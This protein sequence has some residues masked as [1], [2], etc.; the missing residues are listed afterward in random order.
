MSWSYSSLGWSYGV[1]DYQAISVG[2]THGFLET[3]SPETVNVVDFVARVVEP[4][5]ATARPR[6]IAPRAVHGGAFVEYV[7]PPVYAIHF[8]AEDGSWTP[9]VSAQPGR[10]ITE[11]AVDRSANDTL[12]WAE[13]ERSA[14]GFVNTV[15]WTTPYATSA[16]AAA[17]R[18]LA[19]VA[20]AFASGANGFIANRGAI[21]A[22][23]GKTTAV[24]IRTSDGVGWQIDAEPDVYF[25][26]PIWVDDDEVWLQTSLRSDADPTVDGMV[27]IRRDTLGAPTIPAGI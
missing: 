16:A 11:H 2:A 22:T 8:L 6:Q 13:S 24:V 15:L 25:G 21:V 1:T 4:P 5:I 26:A 18:K 20:D 7:A 23:T 17:P 9:V 14:A 19:A 27:R 10:I 12:V 3:W